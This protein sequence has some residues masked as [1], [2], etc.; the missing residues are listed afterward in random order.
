MKD[1]RWSEF[2]SK[3][4]VID[5]T[6]K[7]VSKSEMDL[8][9]KYTL[10]PTIIAL[11]FLAQGNAEHKAKAIAELFSQHSF[12]QPGIKN[13]HKQHLDPTLESHLAETFIS[14]Q[15]LKCIVSIFVNLALVLLP[16]YAADF[17]SDD[18]SAY[19][20]TIIQW[21]NRS[22]QVINHYITEFTNYELQSM[23]GRVSGRQFIEKS[24]E[25]QIFNVL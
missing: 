24:K 11:I 13:D 25:L 7:R 2:Y 5:E 8:D 4:I 21:S 3:F 16:L 23:S 19:L 14:P 1:E 17:P 10:I 6:K 12:Y 18:K 22:Q 9:A 15:Q 20:K